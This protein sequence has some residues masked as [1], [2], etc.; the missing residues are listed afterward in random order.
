MIET[1][2]APKISRS[3][4][5]K[6]SVK[7]AA[8]AGL[9]VAV[10][11]HVVTNADIEKLVETSHE[12]I[13][14]RTGISERRIGDEKTATSDLCIEASKK[15]L[16]DAEVR[17]E[18]LDLIIICTVT[19]DMV[20]PATACFVQHRLGAKKAVAF[21]LAGGCTGFIYG[22]AVGCQF[23]ENGMYQK[24]LIVG[25]DMLS[26]YT[27][28]KDRST[29]I[30]FGDGAGAVILTPSSREDRGILDFHLKTDGSGAT[31]LKIE[32]GGTRLPLTASVLARGDQ[33][34]KME[35]RPV[36]KFAVNAILDGVESLLKK[37]NLTVN[38]V[39]SFIFHQA[40]IRILESAAKYLKI[41]M[42]KITTNVDRFGNTS[43]A[44]V[45]L[46]LEEA[47]LKHKFK[48]GS[49]LVMV[50]FGAGLTW[51]STLVRW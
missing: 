44:S 22:L 8:I 20:V 43:S 23:V 39:D 3:K 9:G 16:I 13:V 49:Y 15:A 37:N 21:D 11:A 34:I 51:G 47:R 31:L 12:W 32:A 17:A 28:W 27:D 5:N 38:D 42:E 1:E 4:T 24:V 36:F 33:Y 10:P 2:L 7:R 45:P 35:G 50:G 46:A 40:N 25:A 30:L 29:C 41:P 19:P 6:T 48:P 26:K 14:S 18:D